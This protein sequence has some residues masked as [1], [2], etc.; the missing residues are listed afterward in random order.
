MHKKRRREVEREKCFRWNRTCANFVTRMEIWKLCCICVSLSVWLSL[1][2]LISACLCENISRVYNSCYC[3][4]T[5]LSICLF[6]CRSIHLLCLTLNFVALL[7]SSF[8]LPLGSSRSFFAAIFLPSCLSF[9]AFV[10]TN[11][12]RWLSIT[13]PNQSDTSWKSRDKF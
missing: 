11:G 6:T 7:K 3:I 9:C 12:M 1:L 4:P 10:S 5:F 13:M 8:V 2:A